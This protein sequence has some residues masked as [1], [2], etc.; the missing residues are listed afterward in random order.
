MKAY[1]WPLSIF[2][3]VPQ[4][5]TQPGKL[6]LLNSIHPVTILLLFSWLCSFPGKWEKFF[7]HSP[8]PR[9]QCV[10][11]NQVSLS[12]SLSLGS[13]CDHWPIQ[14]TANTVPPSGTP[15]Q[16]VNLIAS[17][18]WHL[19]G[20]FS[21]N[22]AISPG[23][24]VYVCAHTEWVGG[25]WVGGNRPNLVMRQGWPWIPCTSGTGVNKVNTYSTP[26]QV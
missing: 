7:I 22:S 10:S 26:A 25:W 20:L 2:S 9:L 19:L 11:G 4:A 6:R 1:F 18:A 13:R 16:P 5:V 23:L 8:W 24:C 15:S 17:W 14:P 12:L 21:R 3:Y